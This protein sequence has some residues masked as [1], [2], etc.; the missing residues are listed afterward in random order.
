MHEGKYLIISRAYPHIVE[1][2][3]TIS[4]SAI[5]HQGSHFKHCEE[6]DVNY[7]NISAV[8]NK[9]HKN[10]DKIDQ[11]LYRLNQSELSFKSRND[12]K[13]SE[14]FSKCGERSHKS[15]KCLCLFVCFKCK[16]SGHI[17]LI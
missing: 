12:I 14:Y 16:E 15:E 7:E 5:K 8:S 13:V 10:N 17:I 1:K 6:N 2:M 9:N 3:Q 11:I 4:T